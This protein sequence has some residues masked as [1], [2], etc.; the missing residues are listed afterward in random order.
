MAQTLVCYPSEFDSEHKYASVNSSYPTSN[1]IGKGSSN[2]SYTQ[3]N[4]TT[5]SNAETY[6]YYKFDLSS[7]PEGATIN[8]VSCTYKGYISNTTT[9]YINTRN[10]QLYSG[11]T[12]KGSSDTFTQSIS[13]RTLTTGTWTRDELQNARIRLYAKRGTSRTSNTYYIRFYGATLTVDYEENYTKYTVTVRNDIDV[14]CEPTGKTLVREGYPFILKLSDNSVSVK[15]N[16]V[17]VSDSLTEEIEPNTH[18]VLKHIASYNIPSGTSST[19]YQKAVGKSAE[20]SESGNDYASG[21]S[22]STATI[23]YSFDF[24]DIPQNTTIESVEV[25]VGGHAESTTNS[26][27]V[28]DLQLYSGDTAKGSKS[29]FT[30]TSHQLVTLTPGTWTRE[31]LQNATLHFTIGY[32]GGLVNGVDFKV[33]YSLPGGGGTYYS[34]AI[35]SVTGEHLIVVSAKQGDTY[36]ALRVRESGSWKKVKAIYKKVGGSWTQIDT[37]DITGETFIRGGN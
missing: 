28:A 17:E 31:E 36:T 3:V 10:A 8:S 29:S 32:Y 19:Y 11:S 16:G 7:I 13:A 18:D 20:S 1:P 5:G 2:T 27:E 26:S 35:A 25:V 15:D 6:F 22:G 23:I 37:S 24:S 21:G 33:T 14:T 30:S 34:Y 9:S 4:L 12:P